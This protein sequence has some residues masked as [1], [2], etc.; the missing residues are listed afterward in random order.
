MRYLPFLL[1]AA[2]LANAQTR[3][4]ITG[5]ATFAVKV[6]DLD[7]AR[8]FYSGVLGYDEIFVS[9]ATG[10]TVFKVNDHQYVELSAGL[11]GD[12]DRLSF[13]GL[14]TSDAR[15][16][17]VYLKSRGVDAPATLSPDA[18]GNLSFTVHDPMGHA[19][20]F[21]QYLKGSEHG[22]LFG[23]HL[24]PRRTS[25]HIIHVGVYVP[26]RAVADH[27]YVD[28]LKCRLMWV[29]G[30]ATNP[31][32]WVS[33]MLPE[34]T[35]WIEYMT[36]VKNPN[37][38]QLGG[39]HHMALGVPDIQTPYQTITERGYKGAKPVLARDGRWLLNT[40]DPYFTR[41]EFMV[42]KPVVT[43]CCTPLHDPTIQPRGRTTDLY[44][45]DVEL[46]NAVLVVTPNG[47]SMLLDS[48]PEAYAGRVIAV[49]K[50]AGIKQIDYAFVSH[51][52]AEHYGAFATIAKEIPIL[53]YIDHEAGADVDGVYAVARE[54]PGDPTGPNFEPY[55]MARRTQ[56]HLLAE[57]GNKI[58]LDGVVL[59]WV[60]SN[61]SSL[62]RPL[63]PA[64]GKNASC[65]AVERRQVD[66][67]EDAQ[68]TGVVL[69]FGKFRFADLGDLTWNVSNGLFCPVNKIGTVDLYLVTRHGMSDP[70]PARSCCSPAEVNALAPRVAILSSSYALPQGTS[71]LDTVSKS[72]GLED[73]WQLNSPTAGPLV[74]NSDP[75]NCPGRWIKVSA[76]LNG[77]FTVTNVGTGLSKS[78]GARLAHK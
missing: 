74:A 13:I 65:A 39:N 44:F 54:Y 27:F 21:V 60:A 72:P 59:N 6:G 57:A 12:E 64:A 9:K 40:F 51:F 26:D 49:L 73:L 76:Q 75:A 30:P 32:S 71:E 14:E 5:I 22:R 66:V 38:R 15:R 1:L 43:P 77:S 8:K 10:G 58:E 29:G 28:I 78:Y 69:N 61:G 4:P 17:A 25:E 67:S 63:A 68:S 31:E 52:H 55:F 20:R 50:E 16:M 56:K 53:T 70:Q 42:R 23:Q 47:K 37:V 3:P 11:K 41:T 34:G 2:C 45:I 19:V 24:S 46:G 7:E 62:P 35:D 33:V 48:G 36:G 18:D